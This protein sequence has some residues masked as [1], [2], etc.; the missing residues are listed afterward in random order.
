MVAEDKSL[1]D[2]L[3]IEPSMITISERRLKIGVHNGW[4]YI[5]DPHI[6]HLSLDDPS[7]HLSSQFSTRKSLRLNLKNSLKQRASEPDP[8]SL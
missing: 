7:N 6:V 1:W 4:R 2:K 3:K 5:H 8:S